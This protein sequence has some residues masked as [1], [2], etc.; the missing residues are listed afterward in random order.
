MGLLGLQPSKIAGVFHLRYSQ[1]RP[2]KARQIVLY[3]KGKTHV[4]FEEGNEQHKL[5]QQFLNQSKIVWSSQSEGIFE[6]LTTLDIP[7]EF[8]IPNNSPST[9]TSMEKSDIGLI[10]YT[11]QAKIFRVSNLLLLNHAKIVKCRLDVKRWVALP[12]PD[13]YATPFSYEFP[14]FKCQ[15]LLDQSVFGINSVILLPVKFILFDMRVCVEKITVRIKE[16]HLLKM[17]MELDNPKSKVVKKSVLEIVIGGDKVLPVNNSNNE[18]MV[19]IEFNLREAHGKIQCNCETPLINIWHM[20]KIKIN[21]KNADVGHLY[22]EKEV[23]VYNI[24]QNDL[25]IGSSED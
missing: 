25:L 10:T 15:L 2:L 5:K 8:N 19:N 22:M 11:L 13:Y 24:L 1:D 16:Y 14:K 18:F 17:A 23:K 4:K 21:M 3:F 9:V 12:S 6:D 20:L 7:F